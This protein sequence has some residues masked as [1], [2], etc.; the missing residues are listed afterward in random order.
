LAFFTALKQYGIDV[1]A[2]FSTE[3]AHVDPTP[4]AGMAQRYW[5]NT[6]CLLN[7]PA[8]QTNFS[9]IS[10]DFWKLVY[11]EMAGLQATAGLTPYL[12]SGEV[13]W[14]YFPNGPV[15]MPYYDAYT[16]QQFASANN[17]ESMRQIMTND[18]SVA[19]FQQ[20]AQL[21]Q[22]VLGN[23]TAG[24]RNSLKVAFP[25]ARYEILYPADVNMPSFN[26]AV[27]LPVADWT[28]SNLTCLKTE[29]LTYALERN[30]DKSRACMR[31][32]A[33]LGF[34]STQRSHLVGITDAKSSWMK[35]VDLAQGEGV[36]SVVLF[37]LDQFCLIG[38]RLPPFVPQRWSRKAA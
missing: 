7:T 22:N 20:E 32:S 17:R 33:G 31:I 29:G 5:D 30:L 14:W 4:E 18:A 13:E 25:T 23:F 35:E 36:E 10:L 27:N 34:P 21:L 19:A 38:Y 8:V 1:V 24:L 15:G 3:L 16:K 11:I 2:A 37:A 6:P 28:P 26:H 12:Q 9:D